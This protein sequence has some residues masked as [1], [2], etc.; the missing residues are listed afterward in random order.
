M[1]TRIKYRLGIQ[2]LG[3]FCLLTVHACLLTVDGGVLIGAGLRALVAGGVVAGTA[4]FA[5]DDQS[6]QALERLR[7]KVK[8]YTLENG[9]RVS[10]Y[11]REMGTPVFSGIVAVRVGGVDEPQGRTGISHLFEHMAFKG[12]DRIGTEDFEAEK[13]LLK[14]Q[15]ELRKSPDPDEKR[16]VDTEK[17][18]AELWETEAFVELMEQR[19]AVDINATTDKEFTKYFESMPRNAFKFWAWIESERIR[20][21]VFRQFYKERDVVLEERR[22]RYDDSPQGKLYEQ[23]LK[24]AFTVH[25]YRH[26]VIGY[27]ED[28]ESLQPEQL[29]ELHTKY[30]VGQ[31]IA[32]SLVG[33]VNPEEDIKVIRK[34]FEKIPSGNIPVRSDIVEPEQQ[35]EKT[36]RLHLNKEPILFVSYHK[37]VY[38]HKDDAPISLMGEI[39]T[40]SNSS[41]LYES[42]VKKQKIAAGVSY[43]EGPGYASPNLF[44]FSLVPLQPNSAEAVLKAFDREIEKFLQHGPFERQLEIA[45]KAIAMEY[46]VDLE[47]NMSLARN[48]ATAHLLYDDWSA[49]LNWYTEM[50]RVTVEDVRS[51]ARKYLRRTNRTIGMVEKSL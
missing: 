30:Y 50:T 33:D 44:L 23:L 48:F 7:S 9:I 16:L 15:A 36:V 18:L 31:N 28:L 47:S 40:G 5:A 17:K 20:K 14:E 38:P 10:F 34:Y 29:A 2:E 27:R 24:T 41:L 13:I 22:M 46:L 37:P 3:M 21:P 32:I 39:L 11:R 6:T 1:K 26:P 43:S 35:E 45:K 12:T 19:G 49:I 25:P 4:A 42:L 51:V 8:T